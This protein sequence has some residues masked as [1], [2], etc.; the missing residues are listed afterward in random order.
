MSLIN[1]E[2]IIN[3]PGVKGYDLSDLKAI[4][5]F[6]V[7]K[8]DKD[9]NII[10]PEGYTEERYLAVIESPEFIFLYKIAAKCYIVEL[11]QQEKLLQTQTENIKEEIL[12]IP[13]VYKKHETLI[14]QQISALE[15]KTD[16]IKH[17]IVVDKY[18]RNLNHISVLLHVIH[19][20]VNPTIVVFEIPI[21]MKSI[22]VKL[23]KSIK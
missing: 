6:K 10:F 20:F 11:K 14:E 2:G 3:L 8:L 7:L 9:N 15:L 22:V 5:H 12:S 23:I 4:V 16:V 21:K 13:E 18:S 19:M 1:S 17:G